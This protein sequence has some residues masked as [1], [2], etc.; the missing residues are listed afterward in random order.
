MTESSIQQVSSAFDSMGSA[1]LANR[2]RWLL[3][4]R[5]VIMA[6][7]HTLPAELFEDSAEAVVRHAIDTAKRL[8]SRLGPDHRFAP[9]LARAFALAFAAL[10]FELR[11]RGVEESAAC[12]LVRETTAQTLGSFV[13]RCW[14]LARIATMDTV[15]R[16]PVAVWFVRLM[17]TGTNAREHQVV[18]SARAVSV[19]VRSCPVASLYQ[20]LGI[21]HL[22][23]RMACEVEERLAWEWD[24]LLTRRK[25]VEGDDYVCILTLESMAPHHG[26]GGNAPV[27]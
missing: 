14:R 13:R 7:T 12:Q 15:D 1:D 9:S 26:G 4:R 25:L 21:A 19:C 27:Y 5:Q 20:E 23:R 22:C 17:L 16:L 10:Y 6:A 24:S 11:G 8:D 3:V 18:P 2:M